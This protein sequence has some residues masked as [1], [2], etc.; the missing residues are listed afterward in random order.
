MFFVFVTELLHVT[1]SKGHTGGALIAIGG[2][3]L[4]FDTDAR[5]ALLALA[6]LL[7]LVALAVDFFFLA[8][9]LLAFL[10]RFAGSALTA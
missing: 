7:R 10:K 1:T 5:D 6:T 9:F 3:I 8:F 2:T 4:S